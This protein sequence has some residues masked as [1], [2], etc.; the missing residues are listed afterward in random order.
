MTQ[1]QNLPS[2]S[3]LQEM[4]E[5]LIF[6][7]EEMKKAANT[8]DSLETRQYT[9]YPFICVIIDQPF[10]TT[11]HFSLSFII[12]SSIYLFIPIHLSVHPNPSICSSIYLFV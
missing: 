3:E 5:D 1:S 11:L 4:Q 7:Q 12:H 8:V 9:I 10:H 6:K 2:V